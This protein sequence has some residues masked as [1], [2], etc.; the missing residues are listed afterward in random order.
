MRRESA[1][2]FSTASKS[3]PWKP[4]RFITINGLPF[5]ASRL[6]ITQFGME[7]AWHSMP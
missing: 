2:S 7:N 4:T 6:T 5:A 1:L 3:F